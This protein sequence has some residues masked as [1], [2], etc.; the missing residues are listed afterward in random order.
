MG[1]SYY[2]FPY[3]IL[4]PRRTVKL[5]NDIL[6]F[7]QHQ[8]ES[9]SE[10]W[11]RFKDLLQKVPRHGI[12]LWLQVQIFYDHVNLVTRRTIDQAAGDV[13]NTSGRRLIELENQVQRLMEA[14]ITLMQ[15][16]QLNKITSSCEICSG[17]H[18]TQYYMENPKQTFVEYASSRT[19]E[20]GEGLVSKFMASQDARLSKFEADFKQQ[21]S[22]MTNKIDTVLKAVTNRMTRALPSEKIKNPKLNVNSTSPVLSARSYLTV[23]P[24][25]SSHPSTSINI[26]KTCS[27]EASHSQA[28]QS[29]A[30]M[31]IGIKQTK[32][33]KPTLEDEFQDLHLNLLVLESLAHAPINNARLDKYVESL[34]LGKN[35]L[36]FVQGEVPAKMEDPMLF[37]LPCRLGNSKPFDTLT[38][39]GSCVNIIP[40]YLFKKLNIRLLKETGHI[41]GLANG[42]KS[43]PV[44]IVKD[45]E[46][47]MVLDN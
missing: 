36:A 24:Q 16:T 37:T 38:D 17:P 29:Q 13:P 33:P 35:G 7:Q 30:R 23:D 4:S 18:D 27:K 43:Y 14:Y 44:G 31:R 32:E 9:L 12:D 10:A 11:T 5:R 1:G 28:N 20:A 2:S 15:S 3:S 22:E 34:E 6:M 25:C 21:Q 47:L 8:G 41:F 40:L 19:D 42:T 46:V 45:I 39:L 26:V